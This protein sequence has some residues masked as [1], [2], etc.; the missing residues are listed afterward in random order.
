MAELE[1]KLEAV[2]AELSTPEVYGDAARRDTLLGSVTRVQAELEV[3][4]ET[5]SEVQEQLE[6]ERKKL[7]AG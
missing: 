3:A 7:E 5:W 4:M 2:N 1:Q 6:A